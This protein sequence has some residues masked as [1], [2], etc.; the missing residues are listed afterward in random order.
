MVGGGL[1]TLLERLG[2]EWPVVQAG[3]GGGIAGAALAGA[4]S[5]AGGLGTLGTRDP[6]GLRAEIRAARE[7]TSQPI[8]V[9]LLLPF[10]RDDHWRAAEEADAIVTFWGDPTALRGRTARPWLHQCGSVAEAAAA[11]EAGAAGVIVQGVEAG[12][13][14]RGTVPAHELLAQVRAVVGDG[15]PL[16]LAGGIADADDVRAALAAGAEA[17]V[18]GTRFVM[19]DESG[20][21]AEY[22]RRIAAADETVHTTLFSMGWPVAPH[23]VVANA[24]LERWEHRAGGMRPPA[25]KRLLDGAAVPLVTRASDRLQGRLA[26]IQHPR[27]PLLSPL[28]PTAGGPSGLLDAGALYAGRSAERIDDVRPAGELVRWLANP[29]VRHAG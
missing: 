2:V 22:R 5:E 26:R 29:V 4:V 28:P 12:G 18:L 6:A 16:W 9:N 24:A 13:H 3:M 8:A 20:A 21:H 7:R 11:E 14:V 23:R 17:A 27:L 10:V 15:Y 1:V 25:W 19:S